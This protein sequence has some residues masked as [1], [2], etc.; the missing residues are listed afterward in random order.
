MSK[1]AGRPIGSVSQ[2]A[3]EAK[4]Q[5]SACAQKREKRGE[6]GERSGERQEDV[7]AVVDSWHHRVH[8]PNAR[9]IKVI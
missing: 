7:L 3:L 4:R 8:T 9:V 6:E 1:A 5:W 2:Y